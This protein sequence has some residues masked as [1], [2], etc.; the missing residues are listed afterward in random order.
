MDSE[1]A[2]KLSEKHGGHWGRHPDYSIED[3]HY[4]VINHDTRLGYWDWVLHKLEEKEN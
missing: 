3:W 2:R 1:E 4:E